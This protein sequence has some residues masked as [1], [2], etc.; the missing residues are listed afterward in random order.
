MRKV[1]EITQ[2]KVFIAENVKGLV[3]LGDAKAIIE[4]DFRAIDQGYMVVPA[5][6]LF[7]PDY[8]IPQR[9]ERVIFIGLSLRYL[10][11]EAMEQVKQGFV[12]VYPQ[13]THSVSGDNGLNPYSQVRHALKGLEEP[14]VS[15]DLAQQK[16]SR[17]K[18]CPGTQGQAEIPFRGIAPTIRS[19]H[20]GNIEYRRLSKEKGGKNTEELDRG[21]IERRLTVRECARIQ[22]FPDSYE[23]VRNKSKGVEYPLS[24][25]GAYKVIGNA[26]PPLLAYHIAHHIETI[27]GTL[28]VRDDSA[29]VQAETHAESARVKQSQKS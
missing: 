2:P 12:D 15:G 14:D 9:R 10:N 5:Q 8:G 4:R 20:H 17:A 24:A 21:L 3:S 28:F 11:P 1:I 7:A 25:S 13:K 26:V 19:E 18:H 23:F 29:K 27:W 6:V 22:T 16:Y